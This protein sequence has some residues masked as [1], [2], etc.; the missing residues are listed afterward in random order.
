MA[1]SPVI[2]KTRDS[3][4]VTFDLNKQSVLYWR[5]TLLFRYYID[6]GHDSNMNIEWEDSDKKKNVLN[7]KDEE[8]PF[9]EKLP[10][11]DIFKTVIK[12]CHN[13]KKVI[14]ITLYYT[15]M[16]CLVQ[17]N[18]CQEWINYEFGRIKSLIEKC[19]K[20]AN[21]RTTIDTE[22]KKL[23]LPKFSD[24]DKDMNDSCS[25]TP[26]KSV[27]NDET[28]VKQ[29]FLN[30]SENTQVNNKDDL[31]NDPNHQLEGKQISDNKVGKQP[32]Q[33][34]SC[35]IVVKAI[36]SIENKLADCH[37]MYTKKL[38]SFEQNIH[39]SIESKLA[40]CHMM[41]NKK[42]ESLEKNVR[43][44]K[45]TIETLKQN[46]EPTYN[47]EKIDNLTTVTNHV[48]EKVNS[49][50]EMCEKMKENLGNSADKQR[51]IQEQMKTVETI[52]KQIKSDNEMPLHNTRSLQRDK[53]QISNENN[54]KTRQ[55]S[56]DEHNSNV[57]QTEQRSQKSA[58]DE[59][60]IEQFG[61]NHFWLIGTSLVKDLQ[62]KLIYRFKKT[63][64]TTLR[65]KTTFGAQKLIESE[66]IKA[67]IVAFQVG[68]NDLEESNPNKV[69]ADIEELIKTTKNK[70]PGC[71]IIINELLPRYYLNI[72]SRNEYERKR[73]QCNLHLAEICD[74]YDA[75][76]VTHQN[77]S[78]IH[79]SDGIHL[80]HE[81][82]TSQY[83]RNLKQI[84]NPLVGVKSD[85]NQTN[86]F[87]PRNQD[88][89]SYAK[90]DNGQRR[91]YNQQNQN[92][93]GQ[94]RYQHTPT[95][96]TVARPRY[97]N[98]YQD[99]YKDCRNSDIN[100]KLLRLALQGF[101]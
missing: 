86:K 57:E 55:T 37:M 83:V 4:Q 15:T 11:S 45:T 30:D 76:Y 1:L 67:K 90:K 79:F 36:Q 9:I 39:D 33:C 71:N 64:I 47:T 14:V 24:I 85:E 61:G 21:P 50:G 28:L 29:S 98:E 12:V 31:V 49:V 19:I 91:N 3:K 17:G 96:N 35:D 7:L 68:S 41:Y 59:E 75:K 93:A 69:A 100:M 89:F 74:R 101:I 81:G 58:E 56:Y 13:T 16:K 78:Q 18:T 60:L 32:D 70:I 92:R 82:G 54:F 48:V 38:E 25:E 80:N 72:Q 2:T 26:T 8:K 95:N 46:K 43:D 34:V 51:Y 97:D 22:I 52:C 87:H 88:P 94:N 10:H 40:N 73:I 44:M 99:D 23:T 62:P 65:D 66:T 6:L 77:I 5:R 20:G 84:V 27:D 42:I 53:S 63:R